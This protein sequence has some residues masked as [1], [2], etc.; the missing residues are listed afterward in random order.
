ML[1]IGLLHNRPY[2]KCAKVVGEVLETTIRTATPLSTT[3]WCGSRSR[4]WSAT[5][6]SIRRAIRSVDGDPPAAYRYTECRLAEA[7][8]ELLR[9]LDEDTVDFAP[10]YN[11]ETTEP[12]VL[13]RRCPGC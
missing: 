7:A 6:S 10:N 8:E 13:P 5:R 12:T 3:R 1:R 11:E 2:N 9:D 4:G